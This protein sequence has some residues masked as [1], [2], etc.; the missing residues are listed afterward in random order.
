MNTI[1]MNGAGNYYPYFCLSAQ[2][3]DA[4]IA[5]ADG[6]NEYVTGNLP[7]PSNGQEDSRGR[8]LTG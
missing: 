5:D 4:V 2:T 7:Y 6:F 8:I 1:T 3:M